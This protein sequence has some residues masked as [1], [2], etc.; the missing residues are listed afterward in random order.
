MIDSFL[1]N[2]TNPELI[3]AIFAFRII[4]NIT[5]LWSVIN[6]TGVESGYTAVLGGLI[7]FSAV[8]T[9][10]L[11]SSWGGQMISYG[12][13]LSQILILTVSAYAVIRND[14]GPFSI[15]LSAAWIG[16]IFLLLLMIPIYGEA[17]GAP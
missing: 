11:L 3:A 8:V 10:L 5:I 17:F 12:E 14:T 1:S 6:I 16:A 2:W 13:Q 15:V 4:F 7:A 9:A